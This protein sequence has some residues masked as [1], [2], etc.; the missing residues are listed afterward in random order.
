L[1]SY[2]PCAAPGQTD[3]RSATQAS[4]ETVFIEGHT[5]QTG[6]DSKNWTLSAERAA[7]TY[8]ALTH[9]AAELRG[10]RNRRGNEILSISGYSDTRPIAAEATS[11]DRA[12]NRRID[13]RFVMDTDPSAGLDEIGGLLAEMHV[14]IDRLQ[15]G[16]D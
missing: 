5:D 3:C 9:T 12:R 16:G 7:A 6:I 15:R 2:A 10:I 4:V 11:E 14:Q 8:L 13:L 1:P